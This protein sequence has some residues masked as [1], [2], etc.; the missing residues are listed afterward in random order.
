MKR[1]SVSAAVLSC[2]FISLTLIGAAQAQTTGIA[3]TDLNIRSGP[4]PE[5]PVVG[6]IKARQQ[7]RI[8][9]CIEGSLW[10]Q[11]DYRGQL[12]WS[13]SQYMSLKASG[14]TIVV[15]EPA[16]VASIPVVTYSAPGL[17]P[18][19]YRP[20]VVA[21]PAPPP[22]FPAPP[23]TIVGPGGTGAGAMGAPEPIVSLAPVIPPAEVGSY[24]AANVAPSFNYGGPVVVGAALPQTVV[25]N[26]VPDYRYQYVYV[27][28]T[29]VLVD[30]ATRRIVYVFR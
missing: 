12:G 22:P 8:L 25:L 20:D 14:G 29:P 4:G 6:L 7:A 1:V 3:T 21:F 5:M 18:P 19:T 2:A 30:P 23:P 15:R 17:P 28:D 13:Y 16:H 11:V 10:C 26:N 24:V 27:N 9:G